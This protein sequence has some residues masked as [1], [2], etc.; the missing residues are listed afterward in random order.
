M[1]IQAHYLLIES[2]ITISLPEWSTGRTW[3]QPKSIFKIWTQTM[4]HWALKT[5]LYFGKFLLHK[6]VNVL[7]DGIW[8]RNDSYKQCQKH[9]GQEDEIGPSR[10]LETLLLWLQVP[11]ETILLDIEKQEW[12]EQDNSWKQW[13]EEETQP[14]QW[15][16]VNE[17]KD[18]LW[19]VKG[20]LPNLL[21]NVHPLDTRHDTGVG[22]GNGRE[23]ERGG[24]NEITKW[25]AISSTQSKEV[26]DGDRVLY[27]VSVKKC[28]WVCYGS[29]FR[30]VCVT[31]V[32]TKITAMFVR[33]NR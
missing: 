15:L 33:P 20:S 25:E 28:W 11:N 23:R 12:S 18:A 9:Q 24:Y 10:T 3:C 8:H 21:A 29:Y 32:D 5:F 30:A 2:N 26:W 27:L 16:H 22:I 6:G 19:N 4:I 13:R 7:S 14:E 17:L 31:K 1:S